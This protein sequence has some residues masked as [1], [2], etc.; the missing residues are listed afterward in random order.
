MR[1]EWETVLLVLC[2]L[3]GDA[4]N[5]LLQQQETSSTAQMISGDVFFEIID[6]MELEYT[7]RL[8]PAKDFGAPFDSTFHMKNVPLVPV[9]P[10]FGCS[11][12]RNAHQ[13]DGNVAFIE[14]GE[15]SFKVKTVVAARAGARAV[16]ITDTTVA[17]EDYFI[18]MIDDDPDEDVNIPA[19]FLMGKNGV[20]IVETLRKLK[21]T[22]ALINMPVNLTF[23][24]VHKVN[25]PPWL[26]W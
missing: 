6:P 17:N 15:C 16:I 11:A 24:P 3:I 25:Q 19:A 21:L 2:V 26:D 20:M 4:N 5:L 9:K 12:L 18:E 1:N 22:H 8:R 14:R 13:I 7:Y 23:I 10:K